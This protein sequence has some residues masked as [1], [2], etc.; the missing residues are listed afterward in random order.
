MDMLH[1]NTEGQDAAEVQRL[2]QQLD[3]ANSVSRAVHLKI[4][5]IGLL[6]SVETLLSFVPTCMKLASAGGQRQLT[7]LSA[8][9]RSRFEGRDSTRLYL[10]TLNVPGVL[11]GRDPLNKSMFVWSKSVLPNYILNL[12]GDRMEMA[13]SIEGRVPFLDHHVV[14]CACRMP[15]WFKIRGATEKYLLR[16]VAKAVI[17]EKVYRREKHPFIRH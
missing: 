6:K 3:S 17:T 5:K 16:E 10:D 14:E 9:F 15:V 11:D 8:D 12:L 4:G 7:L 13:H 1:R 2:L